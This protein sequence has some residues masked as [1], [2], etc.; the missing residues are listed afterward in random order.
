MD[1]II[2]EYADHNLERVT[3]SMST[4]NTLYIK[5]YNNGQLYAISKSKAYILTVNNKYIIVTLSPI[6]LVGAL[7]TVI[8]NKPYQVND[9]TR[10]VAN[11]AG[12]MTY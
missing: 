4:S 11:L 6:E 12:Q 10:M 1:T 3:R 8:A 5:G 9:F 7:E 2:E